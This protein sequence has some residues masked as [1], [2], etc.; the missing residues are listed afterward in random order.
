M[1]RRFILAIFRLFGQS[2]GLSIPSRLRRQRR[3]AINGRHFSL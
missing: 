3:H 2:F 1:K